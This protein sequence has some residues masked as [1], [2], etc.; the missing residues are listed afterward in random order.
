MCP[1]ILG[2][3]ARLITDSYAKVFSLGRNLIKISILPSQR[4]LVNPSKWPK[5]SLFGQNMAKSK[6][7]RAKPLAFGPGMLKSQRSCAILIGIRVAGSAHSYPQLTGRQN[8]ALTRGYRSYPQVIHRV[9]HM[10]PTYN[11]PHPNPYQRFLGPMPII[12]YRELSQ[13]LINAAALSMSP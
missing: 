11:F 8:M 6:Q 12:L 5:P 3:L 10:P 4:N 2:L 9:I 13:F 1:A 7:K